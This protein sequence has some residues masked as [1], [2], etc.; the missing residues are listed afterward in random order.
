M[1]RAMSLHS[2]IARERARL[3]ALAALWRDPGGAVPAASTTA[4]AALAAAVAQC[5]AHAIAAQ[6]ASVR[7]IDAALASEAASRGR[8]VGDGWRGGL[9]SDL[10]TL[11]TRR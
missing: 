10:E 9:D 8:G 3:E 2:L 1:V 7:A 5:A 6:Q 11:D 4:D